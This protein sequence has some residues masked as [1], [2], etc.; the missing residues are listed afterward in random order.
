MTRRLAGR[1][2]GDEIL[3]DR[4]AGLLPAFAGA[5]NCI[6]LAVELV[7]RF[8]S[9]PIRQAVVRRDVL[10]VLG[11][12]RGI[13]TRDNVTE[14]V[15]SEA[16]GVSTGGSNQCT[17]SLIACTLVYSLRRKHPMATA[18]KRSHKHFQLDSAKIKRAQR[19]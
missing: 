12:S 7:Q 13:H 2:R 6:N 19:A 14:T 5:I 16:R 11:G 8:L 1:Q 18:T 15:S 9:C 17:Y 10:R 3:N 4:H